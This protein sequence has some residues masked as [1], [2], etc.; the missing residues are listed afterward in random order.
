MAGTAGVAAA[1]AACAQTGT[2]Q[3][4]SPIVQ[5]PNAAQAGPTRPNDGGLRVGLLLQLAGNFGEVG[6]AMQNAA[7][8]AVFD[9]QTQVQLLP[10]DSGTTATSAAAAAQ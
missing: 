2:V 9:T 6:K 7:Q 8:M 3:R 4:P 1:L 10:R 5:G